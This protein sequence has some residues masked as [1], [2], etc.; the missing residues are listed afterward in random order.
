MTNKTFSYLDSAAKFLAQNVAL[1]LT[2]SGFKANPIHSALI[3][4]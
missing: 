4:R 1:N 3:G 2:L